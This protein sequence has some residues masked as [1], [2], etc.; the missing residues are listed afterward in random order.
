MMVHF[1]NTSVQR[2]GHG[3][4]RIGG[5]WWRCDDGIER[6]TIEALIIGQ[7]GQSSPER[8]LIDT[9]ADRTVVTKELTDR[10]ELDTQIMA[11]EY[12]LV[13]VSG[14]C[15]VVAISAA[16]MFVDTGGRS[17][18][19]RGGFVAFVNDAISDVSILGRDVLDNF[20]LIVSRPRNEVLLLSGNHGYSVTSI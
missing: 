13:G 16:L 17:V 19:V 1:V 10:L 3:Y 9:G 15:P 11:D 12:G 8:F 14:K 18:R 20:D 7:D 4:M 5:Q 6:P 2:S